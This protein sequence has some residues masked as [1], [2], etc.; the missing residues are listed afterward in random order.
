MI[1]AWRKRIKHSARFSLVVPG[2]AQSSSSQTDLFSC[3]YVA[4][5]L[6]TDS[7]ARVAIPGLAY[8]AQ[9]TVGISQEA[10]LIR[11]QGEAESVIPAAQILQLH[12]SQVTIDK[13]VEKDG[14]SAVSW[15]AFDTSINEIVE[16]TS[17][18]RFSD[19]TE[20]K[21]FENT[22]YNVFSHVIKKEVSS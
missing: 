14:L 16:L 7:L 3:L 6:A 4:T 21:A 12:T 22:F 13:A 11:P 8:R 10:F 5:T 17:F 1:I 2:N 20:R 15:Q 18:F 19:L 9:A